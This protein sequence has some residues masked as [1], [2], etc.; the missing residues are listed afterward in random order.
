MIDKHGEVYPDPGRLSQFAGI[1][2]QPVLNLL[3]KIASKRPYTVRILEWPGAEPMMVM[4]DL[5][6]QVPPGSLITWDEQTGTQYANYSRVFGA[7]KPKR[8]DA[9]RARSLV[10][11][12]N[13]A[14]PTKPLNLFMWNDNPLLR[15][16][17]E[18]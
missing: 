4:V 17:R 8:E 9:E 12:Y 14:N 11:A 1:P 18:I 7:T 16:Q 10:L 13:V 2:I 6:E 3:D 5:S 15:K